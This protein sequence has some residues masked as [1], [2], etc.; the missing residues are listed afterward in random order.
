MI[1]TVTIKIPSNCFTIKDHSRFA[2]STKGLFQPPFYDAGKRGVKCV[3]I[4]SKS[5]LEQFQYLPR[6]S[7]LK[8]VR[9]GGFETSLMIEF[10]APK[11]LL[12]NNFDELLDNDFYK[13]CSKIHSILFELGIIVKD[14]KA[15]QNAYVSTIHF[16]KNFLLQDY[17]TPYYY[18]SAFSKADINM[19]YDINSTDF[20]NGGH[21]VKY[22]SND[23][24]VTFYDKIKDLE[25]SVISEKKAM[26]KDNAF[27][28]GILKDLKMLK[29]FEVLR[30][31]VRFGTKKRL[32]RFVVSK[33]IPVDD[34]TFSG[35]FKKGIA[36]AVL[37][38]VFKDIEQ[39]YP[40]ILQTQAHNLEN[41]MIFL[42]MDNPHLKSKELL[43]YI[44]LKSIISEIGTR[45]LRIIL[46][47]YGNRN[48]W[49]RINKNMKSLNIENQFMPF[50]FIKR[51]LEKFEAIRLATLF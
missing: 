20:R 17:S 24:E 33:N 7:V 41:S 22:H 29:P 1:D 43:M 27:Q 38:A 44:G 2:P 6:I 47:A 46:D 9:K 10:S 12:G 48:M 37:Q 32:K 35:L 30:F 13:I 40:R 23:F 25:K 31:E 50:E 28:I 8:M 42:K 4:P 15:I 14:I 51:S 26:E 34:F 18:L 39:G 49:Y 5:D 19:A 45:K 11:L 21:A 3:F 36:K 16:G